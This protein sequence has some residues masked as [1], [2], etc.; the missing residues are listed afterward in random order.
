MSVNK[1]LKKQC[2]VAE[3]YDTFNSSFS[4]KGLGEQYLIDLFIFGLQPEIENL[5]RLWNPKTLHDAY[6]VA[7][8]QE[9]VLKYNQS[10]EVEKENSDFGISV[11][12]DSE[13]KEQNEDIGNSIENDEVKESSQAN[14]VIE[15]SIGFMGTCLMGC[16]D[17]MELAVFDV[18]EEEDCKIGKMELNGA[19]GVADMTSGLIVGGDLCNEVD[20]EKESSGVIID[21][22]GLNVLGE[23]SPEEAEIEEDQS[24]N[25]KK[26]D[27]NK[28]CLVVMEKVCNMGGKGVATS[29]DSV[30]EYFH[31]MQMET[32]GGMETTK[33]LNGS[34]LQSSDLEPDKECP[35]VVIEECCTKALNGSEL[36]SSDLEPD[37]ECPRVV[38]EECCTEN[39][40]CADME[41]IGAI[42]VTD[43]C[44]N[45]EVSKVEWKP[46]VKMRMDGSIMIGNSHVCGIRNKGE[47]RN[48]FEFGE[49][50]NGSE[51]EKTSGIGISSASCVDKKK[52]SNGVVMMG[53]FESEKALSESEYKVQHE[54]GG[55]YVAFKDILGS[56]GVA[57]DG[58]GTSSNDGNRMGF[59]VGQ[60]GKTR[61]GVK[62]EIWKWPKRKK[63]CVKSSIWKWPKKKKA[64]V[65]FD[66][67]EWPNRK[68]EV[69][70][71][72]GKE[73]LC[74][75]STDMLIC[76]ALFWNADGIEGNDPE[77]TL[78]WGEKQLDFW[79]VWV[80]KRLF[81]YMGCC[82]WAVKLSEKFNLRAKYS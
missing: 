6:G 30:E 54:N 10:K 18:L 8:L 41:P 57:I 19:N 56:L 9:F 3:Y 52:Y 65:A 59:K 46:L 47:E 74:I 51:F 23:T 62:R 68:K 32:C 39:M 13:K 20:N 75:S 25:S 80:K 58:N 60:N 22:F 44:R 34:E 31:E 12:N 64:L 79:N 11:D 7:Q 17:D 43:T 14:G 45:R 24:K 71:R 63:K 50:R 73:C 28:K 26:G 82:F 15:V 70:G 78:C 42:N 55:K 1:L 77:L 48:G 76:H 61:G 53:N 72:L 35:R 40:E 16:N 49:E 67:W 69:M 33:A 66:I 21:N 2:T 81:C 38:I 5:V 37:K 36:Q 4:D 29:V 27:D